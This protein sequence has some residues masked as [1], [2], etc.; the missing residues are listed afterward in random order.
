[1]LKYVLRTDELISEDG[2]K[3]ISFGINVPGEQ[4]SFPDIS[5][6]KEKII[7]LID[8]CNRLDLSPEHLEDVI[9]DVI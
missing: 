3:Y 4:L 9:S 7:K 6:R 5:L 1:M 2:E 8:T